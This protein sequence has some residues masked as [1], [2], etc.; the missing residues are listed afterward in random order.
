MISETDE[1]DSD[2]MNIGTDVDT[3]LEQARNNRMESASPSSELGNLADNSS[4]NDSVRE[5]RYEVNPGGNMV[6][7]DMESSVDSGTTMDIGKE[8]VSDNVDSVKS[9][10]TDDGISGDSMEP[11]EKRMRTDKRLTD[12]FLLEKRQVEYGVARLNETFSGGSR[13]SSAASSGKSGSPSKDIKGKLSSTF[14]IVI[15]GLPLIRVLP[16][17]KAI[18]LSLGR[19]FQHV[20]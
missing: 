5:G 13:P 1:V 15:S 12:S 3:V 10:I 7:P 4:D 20:G 16:M 2:S 11:D 19:L 9:D 8:N 14:L 6:V 17:F 18:L